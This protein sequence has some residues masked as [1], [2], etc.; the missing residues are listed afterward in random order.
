[1]MACIYWETEDDDWVE[2]VDPHDAAN[3][4]SFDDETIL[5]KILE[6][7][8][9]PG[10]EYTGPKEN[11]DFAEYWPC[12]ILLKNEDG[13]SG[14]V[15]ILQSPHHDVTAWDEIDIPRFLTNY[16]LNSVK[17]FH[18]PYKSD[19]FLPGAFRQH[20][21]LSDELLPD[22]WKTERDSDG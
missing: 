19:Q 15:R 14:M 9:M 18:R 17:L 22:Q 10:D 21:G 12:K 5:E 7:I 8:G 4:K 1:M 16:P 3:W 2:Q 11:E 6:K 20:I 13:T